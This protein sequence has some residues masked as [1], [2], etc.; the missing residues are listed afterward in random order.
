MWKGNCGQDHEK[1]CSSL[2]SAGCGL[3]HEDIT[4]KREKGYYS[5]KAKTIGSVKGIDVKYIYIY[6]K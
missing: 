1:T 5:L 2:L 4:R 6:I 3:N